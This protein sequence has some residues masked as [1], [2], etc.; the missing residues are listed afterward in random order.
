[1][2][3]AK[4]CITEGRVLNRVLTWHPGIGISYEADPRQA[5][6][7]LTSGDIPVCRGLATP[8][9]KGCRVESDDENSA[10]LSGRKRPGK[11]HERELVDGKPLG[12]A[13]AVLYGAVVARGNYLVVDRPDIG[14]AVEEAARDMP[15]PAVAGWDKVKRIASYLVS[16]PRL[17]WWFKYQASPRGR[18]VTLIVTGPDVPGRER[19]R[20]A[21][22][23]TM[24]TTY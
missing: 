1:M 18:W 13:E 6:A 3:E 2:G 9:V 10:D 15:T 21:D 20:T 12:P 11:L 17:L 24:V 22:R 14:F 5:Q 4:G 23:Y 8:G 7:I 19:V 16:R